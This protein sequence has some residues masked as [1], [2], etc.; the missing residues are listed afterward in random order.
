[1]AE[2][3]SPLDIAEALVDRVERVGLTR[4]R[5]IART[6]VIGA[7]A[8]ATL[9]AYEEAGVT[10]V[11]VE[12][13]WTTAGD[14]RVCPECES[15]EGRSFTLAEARGM[16]PAH[17]N[18]RCA[19]LPKIVGG[20]GIVLNWKRHAPHHAAPQR[21]LGGSPENLP[22]AHAHHCAGH[23]HCGGGA[24]WGAGIR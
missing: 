18:C 8:E 4:A 6:E 20:S 1:M 23:D 9:N 10:G 15:M 21:R 22:R 3:R 24:Q 14:D 12:A 7:H 19:F 13:E 17:P 5:L 11:E 16:I 2:G